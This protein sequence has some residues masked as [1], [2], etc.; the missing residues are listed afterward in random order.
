[1]NL[2][3]FPHYTCGGLLCD[4][5]EDTMS[6]FANNGGIAN[7]AH[8]AGK[9][10]DSLD[11]FTDYDVN[12]FMHKIE[13]WMESSRWIGTHC[14]P[15]PLPLERFETVINIT[16]TTYASKIYR[17]YRAYQLF[18][19]PMWQHLSG[20]ELVDQI[21]QKAKFYLRPAEPVVAPNVF[22]LEFADLV[23]QTEEFD[24]VLDRGR[25]PRNGAAPHMQRWMKQNEFLYNTDIWNSVA[26]QSF[27]HAE[28]EINLG[29]RYQWG[30]AKHYN[31]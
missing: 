13:P 6:E 16:T 14:W 17:W 7:P 18:F 20:E 15:G 5:M 4:I 19:S 2:I 12:E 3:C 29:R 31:T 30:N 10:G 26:A 23:H 22:N 1:M 25:V 9:I 8:N 11:V 28:F 24:Q 27:F 21:T